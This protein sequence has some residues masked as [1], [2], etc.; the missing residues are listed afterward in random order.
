MKR[1]LLTGVGV[2]TILLGATSAQA[3]DKKYDMRFSFW[4][5]AWHKLIPKVEEW[6]ASIGKQANDT[7]KVTVYHSNQLGKGPDHYDMAKTGIADWV[8]VNPGYTPG[9]FPVIQLADMP[10]MMKDAKNG[11]AALTDFYAKYKG[12]EMRDVYTCVA[13]PHDPGTFHAKKAVIVPED[14]KGMKI[15]TANQ[16]IAAYVTAMGGTSVQVEIMEAFETLRNGITDGITVPWGGNYT[17][18]FK[19]VVNHHLN[20]P[21]YVSNFTYNMNKRMYDGMSA[22]Q[23][24][25]I[26]EHCTPE[27]SKNLASLWADDESSLKDKLI[28]EAKTDTNRKIHEINAEQLAKWRKAAEP[29]IN[30]WKAAVKKAGYNPDEVMSDFKK[31]LEKHNAMY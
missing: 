16:T 28:A 25:A 4:V 27:W 14:V 30:E 7:I 12:K 1:T 19:E 21:L 20:A 31:S 3:Q 11:A 18:K 17:L 26:D 5:P 2:V 15:R 6:G 10:F 24:K 8:L 29:L 23:R 22:N 9:R 13:F